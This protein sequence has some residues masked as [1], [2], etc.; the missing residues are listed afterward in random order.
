MII[1]HDVKLNNK[2]DFDLKPHMEDDLLD[3][4]NTPDMEFEVLRAAVVE[5]FDC[6]MIIQ[7]GRSK[8][9]EF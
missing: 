2:N 6:Q 7:F 8:K 4:K 9:T 5:K 1:L 3:L